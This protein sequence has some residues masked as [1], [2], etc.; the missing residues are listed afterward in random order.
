M[1]TTYELKDEKKPLFL[2]KPKRNANQLKILR[3]QVSEDL[4]GFTGREAVEIR[5]FLDTA[6]N[7]DRS[8]GK[9]QTAA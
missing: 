5:R 4:D 9:L 3:T 2:R 8:E 6:R 7:K 1:L